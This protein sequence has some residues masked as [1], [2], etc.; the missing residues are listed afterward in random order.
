MPTSRFTTTALRQAA[1]G[2]SRLAMALGGGQEAY[3]RGAVD[4]ETRQGR[5]AQA[6]SQIRQNDAQ[7]DHYT[8]QAAQQRAETENL[9]RRPEQ[10]MELA[11]LSSGQSLPLV[12]ALMEATRNGAMPTIPGQVLD[13]PNV[14]GSAGVPARMP[15]DVQSKI[16]QAL[17]RLAPVG[18]NQKD[19]GVDDWAKAQDVYRDQDLSQGV[20]D[21]RLNRDAVAA[22]QAAAAGKNQY[23]ADATGS[24][25]D[26]FRGALNTDNPM[27]RSTISL[28]GDQGKALHGV[29][30][31]SSSMHSMTSF[32]SMVA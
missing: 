15:D 4:E 28:K 23:H 21:G 10:R 13:G 8:A 7:A 17:V 25:L 3:Q 32:S 27:A 20:I 29:V 14:D 9:A 19:F 6:L 18:L 22:A 5:I 11:A 24:V 12:R 31:L 1:P 26:L 30:P 2:L 16:A